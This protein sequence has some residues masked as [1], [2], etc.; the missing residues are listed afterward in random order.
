MDPGYPQERIDYILEDTGAALVLS[1]RGLSQPTNA[2][3]SKGEG[4]LYRP[5]RAVVQ[6]RRYRQP[7]PHSG[8]TDLAYVIYTSGTTGK[9][10]GVMVE[11]KAFAQFILNF[12]DH[13]REKINLSQ[14]NV[15]S[16]TNYVF[17]IFGLEYALPLITG[18]KVVLSSV[19]NVRESDIS[20]NHIIQQ[21]PSVLSLLA[22]KFP[23]AL[24][25][26]VCL[27]GG[28]ALPHAIAKKLL[29]AFKKVI[30][31]YGPTETVIWSSSFEVK[32]A[33]KPY[34][35]A[36]LFNERLYFSPPPEFLCQ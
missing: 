5:V 28:E 7:A 17:D 2:Q 12:D 3:A 31:V 16:L 27:V 24:S 32:D 21:T 8:S 4:Y 9:P 35:G 18:C 11:H 26:A 33:G 22:E 19:D 30:N 6:R 20:G 13:L 23:H 36:P 14:G 29:A 34:I 25:G 1:Q 10:K 15:L